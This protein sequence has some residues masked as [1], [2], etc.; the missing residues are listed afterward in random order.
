M[1]KNHIINPIRNPIRN[2]IIHEKTEIRTLFEDIMFNLAIQFKE[3]SENSKKESDET[4]YCIGAVIFSW[5]F[6]EGFINNFINNELRHFKTEMVP[7]DFLRL[8]T[9]QKYVFITKIISGKSFSKGNEPFCSLLLLNKLRNE[10]IHYDAKMEEYYNFLTP[11]K[12]EIQCKEKFTIREMMPT[13]TLRRI[14]TKECADWSI[15]TSVKTVKK[16]DEYVYGKNCSTFLVR[17]YL[18]FSVN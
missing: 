8:P 13:G 2:P 1:S 6:L 16:F 10:L 15:R 3:D 14:L 18:K 7:K 17:E 9:V 11:K 4:K 12:F 5:C